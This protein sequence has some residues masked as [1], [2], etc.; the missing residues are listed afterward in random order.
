MHFCRFQR[1]GEGRNPASAPGLSLSRH[2]A[3]ARRHAY[4][5]IA[6]M[7]PSEHRCTRRSPHVRLSK[8]PV[9]LAARHLIHAAV[10]SESRQAP[11]K[12]L[13]LTLAERLERRGLQTW[14]AEKTPINSPEKP[15][16]CTR[17]TPAPCMKKAPRKTS[18][19]RSAQKLSNDFI[20]LS[21]R[22]SP[23]HGHA[24][25]YI[26]TFNSFSVKFDVSGR[27]P[28]GPEK[29]HLKIF[30]ATKSE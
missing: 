10:R 19:L 14:G 4:A 24:L 25:P 23:R 22:Y 6:A 20:D 1:I 30:A 7:W 26:L 13:T 16:L 15:H 18:P 21:D 9:N 17:N 8:W 2:H 29:S 11:P 27:N 3:E 28:K 12:K 5:S